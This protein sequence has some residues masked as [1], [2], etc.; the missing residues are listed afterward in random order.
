MYLAGS[1]P[2]MRHQLW[3]IVRSCLGLRYLEIW[4]MDLFLHISPYFDAVYRTVRAY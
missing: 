4:G 1:I 3:L 2:Y